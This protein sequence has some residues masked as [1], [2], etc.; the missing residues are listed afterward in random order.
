A[1]VL[2]AATEHRAAQVFLTDPAVIA[3]CD[4]DPMQGRRISVVLTVA[5]PSARKVLFVPA[6]G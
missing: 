3:P 6:G 5:D 4:G 2:H 1:V